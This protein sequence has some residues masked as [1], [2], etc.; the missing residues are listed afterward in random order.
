MS[1]YQFGIAYDRPINSRFHY[2][3][4]FFWEKD[5]EGLGLVYFI[6]DNL[7]VD[8]QLT[9]SLEGISINKETILFY[10]SKEEIALIKRF[11]TENNSLSLE[12]DFLNFIDEDTL[13][14]T[15]NKLFNALE[16]LIK[17]K[18]QNENV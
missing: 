13:E 17:Y 1:K 12:N 14:E 11:C 6:N 7:N 9:N 4:L 2:K 8:S 5:T 15:K 18:E 10:L 16:E 3:K